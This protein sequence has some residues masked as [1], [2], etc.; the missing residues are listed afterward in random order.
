[1]EGERE[2]GNKRRGIWGLHVEIEAFDCAKAGLAVNN[3]CKWEV[4][5]RSAQSIIF[6][7]KLFEETVHTISRSRGSAKVIGF[8]Y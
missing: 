7:L 8:N 1:M 3:R 2:R 4:D 6:N 5:V